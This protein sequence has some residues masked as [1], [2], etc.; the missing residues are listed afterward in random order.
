MPQTEPIILHYN[1]FFGIDLIGPWFKIYLIPLFGLICFF[2][3]FALS[4]IIYKRSKI[5]SYL[6]I[7]ASSLIQIF[8]LLAVIFLI[9][10]NF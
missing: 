7:H 2:I 10:Q 5:L 6:L 8:I 4:A 9:F 3:N 1:I